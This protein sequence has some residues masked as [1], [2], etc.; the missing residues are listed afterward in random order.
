MGVNRRDFLK[1]TAFAGAGVVSTGFRFGSGVISPRITR[2]SKHNRLA[3]S[4]STTS[5]GTTP[6]C[7]LGAYVNPM[8]DAPPTAISNFES[9]IGRK[10]ATTRHYVAWDSVLPGSLIDWSASTGHI[11]YI[12]WHAWK[13]SGT[14]IPWS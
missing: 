11:P 1:A 2:G 9:L 10:L 3:N 5:T 12:G 6:S 8:R 13:N 14:R 4:A 7:L